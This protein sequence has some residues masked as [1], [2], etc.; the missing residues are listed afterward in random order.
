MKHENM[1]YLV[2]EDAERYPKTIDKESR[3]QLY[4]SLARL[5]QK[6]LYILILLYNLKEAKIGPPHEACW[7]KL[8]G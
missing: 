1:S 6:R 5:K 4:K 8:W 2:K 3:T 7:F